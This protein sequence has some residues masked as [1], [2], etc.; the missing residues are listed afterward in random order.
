MLESRTPEE[1][2]ALDR[3]AGIALT[4]LL[5][6]TRLGSMVVSDS[7]LSGDAMEK[8]AQRAYDMAEAMLKARQDRE[9]YHVE[10]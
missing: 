1:M 9:H 4:Y 7:L 3:F 10:G 5:A 6:E 2:Q 8:S